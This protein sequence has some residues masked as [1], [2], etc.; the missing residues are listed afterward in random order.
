MQFEE[1]GISAQRFSGLR[2]PSFTKLGVDIGRSFL[3]NKFVSEFG[4]LAAFSNSDDSTLS[5]IENDA[6]ISH[7]LTP[8]ENYWKGGRDVYTNC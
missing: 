1:V 2:G 4:Y 5:D 6:K 7:F 8:F 3:H